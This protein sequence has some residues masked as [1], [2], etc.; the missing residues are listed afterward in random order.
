MT[1][2]K[3]QDIFYSMIISML[4]YPLTARPLTAFIKRTVLSHLSPHSK[5][6]FAS[7]IPRISY[8]RKMMVVS[9]I[10]TMT[11]SIQ[12]RNISP[13]VAEAT[14]KLWVDALNNK[15][16]NKSAIES[17]YKKNGTKPPFFLV[18]SPGHACN[19][20]CKG[21][22]AGSIN[23]GGKLSWKIMD[24][25]I[26]QARR[27]WGVR[28]VVFSGGEPFAYYSEGKDI[29]DIAAKYEDC[30]FLAFTNGTLIDKKTASKIAACK[31]ITP[32][33]SVEGMKDITDSRRGEGTFKK[34]LESIRC[35][36]EVGSPFGISVTVNRQNYLK[37]LDNEFTDFFFKELGAFYGFY[38]QYLPI[39]R[40]IDFGLMPTPQQRSA[41]RE[42][43]W[44][45]IEQKKLFL[46]DFWNHGPLVN[47]CIAGGREGGYLYIDWD[48]NIMPCVFA[49]YVVGNINE[50]FKKGHDL[51]DI[52]NQPFLMS[53]RQWQKKYGY[54]TNDSK[55]K[56]NLL[57][58][59]PYRDHYLHF[60]KLIKDSGMSMKGSTESSIFNDKEYIKRMS[61]YDDELKKVFDPVWERE[62]LQ[63]T[64]E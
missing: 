64:N 57:R 17:F 36:K 63:S 56:G 2:K 1:D 5:N 44:K 51:N 23:N 16:S 47:G 25:L 24:D 59:C 19:L 49:P 50:V 6:K 30:L 4:Y 46:L 38:F 45:I 34:V 40:N 58:P 27:V 41:F 26:S 20:K 8:E 48:G 32:A 11:R 61:E 7:K 54:G 3:I 43:I 39:G 53:F 37:V 13:K 18:I 29:L 21:C 31:N 33:F 9:I 14:L 35:M 62:Y 60:L 42:K 10:E 15:T 55:N 12:K 52:Y 22:Y 28:L